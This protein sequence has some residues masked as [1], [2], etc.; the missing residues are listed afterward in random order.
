ML[1]RVDVQIPSNVG[2]GTLQ[3]VVADA[4]MTSA[5]ERRDARDGFVP[6]D[7]DQL[8]R[9]LNGIRKNNRLYIRLSRP[10]RSSAIVAGE[11]LSSL[12]PSVL[13]VMGADQSSASFIPIRNSLLW[14]H[15]LVTEFSV[16]GSRLLQ[17]TVKNP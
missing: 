16:T 4:A 7:L 17:I 14:E 12:P 10:D 8:I 1:E 15:E 5:I 3:L 6:R 9:A 11:Y 2:E 13:N